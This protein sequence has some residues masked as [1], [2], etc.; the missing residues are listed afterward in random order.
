MPSSL[1]LIP[2]QANES[3]KL[4]HFDCVFPPHSMQGE[5]FNEVKP[6]IQSAI[7]GENVCIFAYG[8]TGAGKTFTMEGPPY[9]LMLDSGDN[10]T[11][12]DEMSGI[13]P[14][15]A[16]FLFQEISRLKG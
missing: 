1:E 2:S 5:I 12:L 7:D 15:T 13:L 16:E 10:S 6:F 8:Q 11:Q 9:T 14:R 4:F 3:S